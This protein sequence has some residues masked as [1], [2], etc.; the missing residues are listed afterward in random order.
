VGGRVIRIWGEKNSC[1]AG[2]KLD[3][4]KKEKEK[5]EKRK[6]REK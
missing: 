5:G 1:A 2:T 4:D 6:K 3:Q